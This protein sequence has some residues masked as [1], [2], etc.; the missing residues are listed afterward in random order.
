MQFSKQCLTHTEPTCL[1]LCIII[2]YYGH[3]DL[4][5]GFTC[6]FFFFKAEGGE[7]SQD[8]VCHAVLCVAKGQ[9]RPAGPGCC[10]SG[11][12]CWSQGMLT[13]CHEYQN[14]DLSL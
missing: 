4:I 2:S 7:F 6:V 1:S 5:R 11:F 14:R 10:L 9:T 8:P 13:D 12:A 3:Y